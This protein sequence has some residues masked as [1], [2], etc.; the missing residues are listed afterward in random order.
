MSDEEAPNALLAEL[1]AERAAR[2]A[3]MKPSAANAAASEPVE[4][5]RP[6]GRK[7]RRKERNSWPSRP[8]E[9]ERDVL[10]RLREEIQCEACLEEEVDGSVF[11][12]VCAACAREFSGSICVEIVEH[13]PQ[14]KPKGTLECACGKWFRSH[15]AHTRHQLESKTCVARGRTWYPLAELPSGYSYF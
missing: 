13:R 1:H 6:N 7:R 8:D 10:G 9:D 2:L 14:S 5:H 4:R 12:G 3:A 11:G 15:S